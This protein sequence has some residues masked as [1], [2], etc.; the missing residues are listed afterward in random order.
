MPIKPYIVFFLLFISWNH[1]AYSKSYEVGISEKVSFQT[2]DIIKLKGTDYSV[3]I[4][5]FAGSECAVP[6]FNCGSGY[7]PPHP[8]YNVKCGAIAPCPYILM[9]YPVDDRSG[10]LTIENEESCT[11]NK[12]DNCFS[13]YAGQFTNDEG[14]M[15]LKSP[16]GRYYCLQRFADSKRPENKALCEQLPADIYAL[17]WNCFYEYAIRYKDAS[18]CDKYPASEFSG[19]DRCLLKMAE[20]LKDYSLCKKI[21]ASKEHSYVDQCQQLEKKAKEQ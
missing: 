9:H 2:G 15:K 5:F 3:E 14:C 1:F 20:I 11:K 10:S 21:S 17:R 12:L 8:T 19:R 4:G 16:F 6:G 18:L 13:T 7:R